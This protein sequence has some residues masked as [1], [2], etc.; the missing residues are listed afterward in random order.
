MSGGVRAGIGGFVPH[1]VGNT[2]LLKLWD[3]AS[4]HAGKPDPAESRR[5]RKAFKNHEDRIKKDRGFI[6]DQPNYLDMSYGKVSMAYAGCEIIAV[7][8]AI[9]YMTGKMP[10]LDRLI[11][12][13]KKSGVSFNGR[14]GTSPLALVRFFRRHGFYAEPA[15]TVQDMEET[16]SS[17]PALI[18]VYYNDRDDIGAMVHTIF[19]SREKIG[20]GYLFTAHNAGMGGRSGPAAREFSDLVGKLSGGRAREILLIGIE[21]RPKGD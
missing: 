17:Y 7:F 14:F 11:E 16:A 15:F 9:S 20:D 4:K 19:I 1:H 3:S 2:I 12:A 8:N 10:R 13:F 21:E 6:E 18:L 5:N